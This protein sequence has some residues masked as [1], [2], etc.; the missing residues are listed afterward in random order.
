MS[1]EYFNHDDPAKAGT[2]VAASQYNNTMLAVESG[3]DKLPTPE[4]FLLD[5]SRYGIATVAAT[6]VF[7]LTLA[8]LNTI[9]NYVEGMGVLV[10]FPV[11]N[12]GA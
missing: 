6:N 12:T 3:F 1:N 10:K 5:N 4:Q 2:K 8:A 9:T 7:N 11:D